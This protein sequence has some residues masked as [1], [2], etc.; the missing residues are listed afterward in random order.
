MKKNYVAPFVSVMDYQ[1]SDTI[2]QG[3]NCG[4]YVYSYADGTCNQSA[5]TWVQ[6]SDATCEL[7]IVA[8]E[9]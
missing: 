7:M 4:L 6:H 3:S 5:G 8:Y 1:L 9:T 2:A